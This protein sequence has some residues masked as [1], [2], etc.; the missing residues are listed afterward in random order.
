MLK[1]MRIPGTKGTPVVP[2]S[3]NASFNDTPY[4]IEYLDGY[5]ICAVVTSTAGPITG[6]LKLQASNNAFLNNTD[7]NVN[8]AAVWVDIPASSMSISGTSNFFWN[9]SS[10]FYEAFRIS[11]TNAS[12]TGTMAYYLLCK[13]Q[14]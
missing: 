1:Q 7:N 14:G 12:G 13:G 11:W 6:T 8:P 2:L 5:S 9:V 4:N 10:A 3:L